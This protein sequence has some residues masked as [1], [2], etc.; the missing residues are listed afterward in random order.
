MD[1]VVRSQAYLEDPDSG[2]QDESR[3]QST[4]DI[5]NGPSPTQLQRQVVNDQ[6]DKK[7]DREDDNDDVEGPAFRPEY[8]AKL[9][10]KPKQM[11]TSLLALYGHAV[12]S[13]RNFLAANGKVPLPVVIYTIHFFFC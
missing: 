10:Y 9:P 5:D 3:S 2:P 13:A 11:S 8:Y 12:T 4:M 6:H 7:G 1:V